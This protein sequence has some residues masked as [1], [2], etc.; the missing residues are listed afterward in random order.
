MVGHA[1]GIAERRGLMGGVQMSPGTILQTVADHS[2]WQVWLAVRPGWV[3]ISEPTASAAGNAG[4]VCCE[5]QLDA[6]PL[7]GPSVASVM[8]SRRAARGAGRRARA[9]GSA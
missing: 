1:F 9:G 6:A 3:V 2:R 8:V 5:N 4:A 7:D